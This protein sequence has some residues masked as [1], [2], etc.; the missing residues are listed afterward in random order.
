MA[1]KQQYFRIEPNWFFRLFGAPVFECAIGEDE[2]VVQ[3]YRTALCELNAPPS[4]VPGFFSAG[5][6]L[7]GQR[8]ASGLPRAQVEQ[9]IAAVT[10]VWYATRAKQVLNL[11]QYIQSQLIDSYL[12]ERIWKQCKALAAQEI[13][14]WPRAIE[15]GR[16]SDEQRQA[17]LYVRQVAAWDLAAVEKI[18][19]EFIGKQQR[20]YAGLFNQVESNPLTDKQ[21]EACI[22]MEHNNLVLAGAGT[23]KTSTMVGRAG[24]LL[25]SQQAVEA[26]ILLLAFGKD[27]AG[28]MN[29]RIQHRLG[30]DKIRAS[31]FHA[32]GRH[33]ITHVEGAKA[34]ISKFADDEAA[35]KHFVQQSFNLLLAQPGY[36]NKV[37]TYFERFQ[38]VEKNPFEFSSEGDYIAY[39]RD[40]DIRTLKG[41]V[42]KSYGE[43]LIANWLFKNGVEYRYEAPYE[44]A[45][46]TLEFRQYKPDFYLP[47]QGLYLEYWG[48][49]KRGN[50]APFVNKAKYHEGMQWKRSIHKQ[51]GTLLVELRYAD[52]QAG[53]LTSTLRAKLHPH[54]VV[55]EPLPAEAVLETLKEFGA[56]SA[57]A[58]IL[59][60]VMSLYKSARGD[61][62]S[63]HNSIQGPHQALIEA[64]LA[65]VEPILDAYQAELDDEIDFEDMIER[66]TQYVE[67]GRFTSPWRHILVD[68]FQDISAP[69]ARLVKAL[70]NAHQ[71]AVLFCVGDD[72]QA[73]YRFAGADVTLT[74]RYQQVFGDTALTKLDKTYRF[75]DKISD[76]AA[77]F[78]SQNPEQL[79]KQMITHKKAPS[80]AV[81]LFRTNDSNALERV[82]ARIEQNLSEPKSVF[83]LAR[84]NFLLPDSATLQ[85]WQRNYRKLVISAH[86]FHRSKGMEADY[87]IVLGLAS[88]EA[89][90]PSQKITH[91]LVDALLPALEPFPFA[92]ERRLFY[93]AIT[94][95]RERVYLLADMAKPS[96]FIK[97]L[98]RDGYDI[99][100]DE[101]DTSAQQR[102][103]QILTCPTCDSGTL[104]RRDKGAFGP[105][106]GCSNYPR[107]EHS[108]NPCEQ[109][110][111]PMRLVE[112]WKQ[113]IN[114]ACQHRVPVCQL[115]GFEMRLR[116]SARGPFWSC[117]NYRKSQQPSCGY[118]RAVDAN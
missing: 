74:T 98:L 17:F 63:L 5:M 83:V 34:S 84:Y 79:P 10:S 20:H 78:I 12:R 51:H 8:L 65:L 116:Q 37:L 81:S 33:I 109:C 54:Q 14:R 1:N 52:H 18:R 77:R 117:Q 112:G 100:K 23:G 13:S 92:E 47:E 90:F 105:F 19:M 55:F 3:G 2:L 31:T 48:V 82:L 76:V 26:E 62:H 21:Q 104:Q 4:L 93:V 36:K 49:D 106:L 102:L 111:K 97:E 113:C 110:Q 43:L 87:V 89:G 60:Q 114:K 46:K 70:R 11:R 75:N 103:L 71:D 27:A 66:A 67:Q 41:E 58:D 28:E 107:C 101:F 118:T 42:V 80:A 88:G 61:L 86:S 72:W 64:A 96:E 44:I 38:Y 95:A 69:R 56:V 57:L 32:L 115:C 94:R 39:L 59:T 35:K 73:I 22:R 40:N 91:P 29:E 85:G 45:T 7:A 9:C 68:E 99:D 30:T 6:L 24:Y 53:K 25:A 16:L 15:P 108:E 50:T